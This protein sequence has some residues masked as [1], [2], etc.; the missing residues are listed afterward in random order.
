MKFLVPASVLALSLFA[1]PGSPAHAGL[2][3]DPV[4]I[5]QQSPNSISDANPNLPK[6][7]A[8]GLFAE[9]YAYADKAHF[10]EVIEEHLRFFTEAMKNWKA[11]ENAPWPELQQHVKDATAQIAPAY[12]QAEAALKKASSASESDWG[13]AQSEARRA[14]SDLQQRYYQLHRPKAS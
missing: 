1:I 4:H 9:P 10:V 12:E 6:F 13:Q 5:L 14:F 11:D 2:A 7:S 8:V 3:E